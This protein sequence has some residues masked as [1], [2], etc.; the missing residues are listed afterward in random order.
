VNKKGLVVASCFL[1]VTAIA[2]YIGNASK[3]GMEPLA[4]PSELQEIEKILKNPDY[5]IGIY[6]VGIILSIF[7]Y[8]LVSPKQEFLRSKKLY[9][10]EISSKPREH[11]GRPSAQIT[12]S[13][14][15]TYV[16]GGVIKYSRYGPTPPSE[17][18]KRV[19]ELSV[20]EAWTEFRDSYWEVH[21]ENLSRFH[22]LIYKEVRY[23][24]E[25][26]DEYMT[27]MGFKL[28]FKLPYKKQD[29]WVKRVKAQ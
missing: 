13:K 7:S 15:K 27:Y 23:W 9:Q 26:Y 20:Q 24:E 10:E 1:I 14:M 22:P 29:F 28:L 17:S 25:H 12:S 6:V 11:I 21:R 8:F 18:I 2:F 16:E 3:F 4:L 19:E 5:S